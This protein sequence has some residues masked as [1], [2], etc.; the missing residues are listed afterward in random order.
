M[1]NATNALVNIGNSNPLI[2]SGQTEK[3]FQD[4]IRF[5]SED[6]LLN[7]KE[8]LEQTLEEQLASGASR[9]SDLVQSMRTK[10]TILNRTLGFSM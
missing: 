8:Q 7:V 6:T 3:S 1:T 5:G 9:F 2:I 4:V 10:L